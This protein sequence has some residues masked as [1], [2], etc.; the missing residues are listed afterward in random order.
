MTTKSDLKKEASVNASKFSKKSDLASSISDI[1][2]LD[3]DK[4]A[5]E[6]DVIRKVI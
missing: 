6:N 5:V 2:D 3:T 1:D 4:L